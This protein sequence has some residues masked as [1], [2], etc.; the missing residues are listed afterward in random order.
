MTSAW[1]FMQREAQE[2]DIDDVEMCQW[3]LALLR[4]QYWSYQQSHWQTRGRPYYGNHL[5]FQRLYESVTDH[6][7][8]LAEKM[9]AFY[10]VEAV[11]AL[12]LGGKFEIWVKRWNAT[13]CLHRRGLQSEADMQS[14]CKAVYDG[15]KARG[16]LSLGLDDFLM[17]IANDHETNTYLLQQV[18][19]VAAVAREAAADWAE[20]APKE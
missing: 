1:S 11:D 17:A 4:A 9:V 10:G 13:D 7:D 8:G 19:R 15:L 6:V 5:L 18:L 12:D 14:V 2:Q 3:L 20:M 16:T